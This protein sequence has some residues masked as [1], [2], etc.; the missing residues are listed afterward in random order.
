MSEATDILR[1]F[2]FAFTQAYDRVIVDETKPRD[3]AQPMLGMSPEMDGE[4]GLIALT[5]IPGFAMEERIKD[6]L[7]DEAIPMTLAKAGAHIAAFCSFAWQTMLSKD[8]SER[9]GKAMKRRGYPREDSAKVKQVAKELGI[10]ISDPMRRVE[11][12]TL[13]A[14]SRDAEAMMCAYVERD[15][16]NAPRVGWV[17]DEPSEEDRDGIGLV[18]VD[19]ENGDRDKLGGRVIEGLRKGIDRTEPGM[20]DWRDEL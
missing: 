4:V 17:Y 3:D 16:E 7:F 12:C 5:P 15:G 18:L 10:H 8:E 11:V 6:R 2:I 1:G 20:G 13:V 14:C 9:I 19:R